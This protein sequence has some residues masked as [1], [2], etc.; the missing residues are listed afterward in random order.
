MADTKSSSLLQW[1]WHSEGKQF[2]VGGAWIEDLAK[3]RLQG[4]AGKLCT[5]LKEFVTLFL[6][7]LNR[8][9]FGSD[10]RNILQ[11]SSCGLL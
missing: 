8:S 2:L 5:M 4:R 9:T 11:A 1:A 10:Y 7:C 6:M 3:E